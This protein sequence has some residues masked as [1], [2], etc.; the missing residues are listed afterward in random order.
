MKAHSPAKSEHSRHN[1]SS[2]R[3]GHGHIQQATAAPDSRPEMEQ[4]QGLLSLMAGSPRLQ[5]QCACGSPSATGG[6]CAACEGKAAGAGSQGMQAK[7]AIGAT[8]D[9]LER[10]ADRIAD[11]V[12][13]GPAQSSVGAGPPH[14]HRFT[15]QGGGQLEVAPA[16][17][18]SVLASSG[19]PLEPA[20]RQDMEHRFGY[21]F[22]GV[23]VHSDA[24]AAHS[25]RE[26]SAHAYTVGH[27]IVF[28]SGQYTPETLQG[29]RLIAHEL[30]HVVQQSGSRLGSVDAG[31]S[32][33]L[34]RAAQPGD[35]S[36]AAAV[37]ERAKRL[38]RIFKPQSSLED[39]ML[40]IEG[41]R[42]SGFA[43]GMYV[44]ERDGEVLTIT[45]DE[46]NQIHASARKTLLSGLRLLRGKAE[47][48]QN[49][50]D[51]Q[52]KIDEDQWF[53][54]GAVRLF[55]GIKDPGD[56]V[57]QNVRY[58]MANASASQAMLE[59]GRLLRAAEFFTKC[60]RFATAGKKLSQ[61]YV[62]NVIS[63]ADTTVTVLEVTA[64]VA[65]ATV[66]VIGVVLAAPAIVAAAKAAPLVITLGTSAV[67]AAPVVAVEA[68]ATVAVAAPATAAVA[69]PATAA[70]AAPA[71]AAVAIPATAAVAA[72]ATAAVAAPAAA[73][74]ATALTTVGLGLA[75]TTLS[76]DSPREP[77]TKRRQDTGAYPIM[78]PTLFGPPMLFG[79]PIVEFV[80][81]PN[82]ERDEDYGWEVRRE[83]WAR[84]RGRDPDLLPRDFHAHHI[85]PLF[86]GGL[87]G[88]RGNITFLP[89]PT[90]LRGH[91]QLKYQPQ[92]SAPPPPLVPL[93]AN[94]YDHPLG[95]RYWLA[96]FK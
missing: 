23:R 47:Y 33:Y 93:P 62:D 92:M 48:A 65:G 12:L 2:D 50:Y 8:D 11:Q 5:R 37:Q 81:T 29:R 7:L 24:A 61:A 69:I 80:R 57:R 72:P 58:A 63:T 35:A 14:I 66:V 95:T 40:V 85:V 60:E 73:A 45:Q 74:S 71:T 84:H 83:L 3:G 21:S 1:G 10:E 18:D 20:L 32:T 86:L 26:V 52:H 96:G 56:E 75:A 67:P 28:G 76:S 82:R 16:S 59:Q 49:Q 4:Q 88:A 38:I 53:V 39:V 70:I 41:I 44:L 25:A 34:A 42:A 79:V 89:G 54:S 15:P 27:D 43:S 55:G 46:F 31:A 77:A 91:A 6:S 94:I 78:W 51:A 64:G 9:P 19:K 68:A 22:S 90:H 17:V 87:E 36:G 30:T 13:S